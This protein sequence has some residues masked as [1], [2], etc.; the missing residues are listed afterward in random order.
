M[1]FSIKWLTNSKNKNL[2]LV[3]GTLNKIRVNLPIDDQRIMI[4]VGTKEIQSMTDTR[5]GN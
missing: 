2:F 1:E 5:T 4:F 3:I